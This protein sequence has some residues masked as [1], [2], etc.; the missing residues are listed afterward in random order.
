MTRHE[1]MPGSNNL[2]ER[3]FLSPDPRIANFPHTLVKCGERTLRTISA[4]LSVALGLWG[5]RPMFREDR[6]HYLE[7]AS[8][9]IAQEFALWKLDANQKYLLERANVGPDPSF[10]MFISADTPVPVLS[11][12]Y[13]HFEEDQGAAWFGDYIDYVCDWISDLRW[14]L[15][16]LE[17]EIGWSIFAGALDATPL[18][19]KVKLEF[20]RNEIPL[21]RLTKSADRLV[22]L[23]ELGD[24]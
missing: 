20:Q 7:P 24:K 5:E 3:M 17:G 9:R 19:S 13:E 8:G 4:T 6:S 14:V 10:R 22:W 18:V 11:R 16:P 2:V 15:I 23:D 21:A 12:T 1:L